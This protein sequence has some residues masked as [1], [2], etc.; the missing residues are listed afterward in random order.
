MTQSIPLPLSD[1]LEAVR[2]N[3]SPAAPESIFW[4]Y[5]YGIFAC[6][7]GAWVLVPLVNLTYKV[8]KIRPMSA[9]K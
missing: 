8:H 7:S 2:A 9:P 5:F 4:R 6:M 1:G 3:G